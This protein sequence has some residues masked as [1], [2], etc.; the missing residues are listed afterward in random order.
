[1]NGSNLNNYQKGI[2]E[3]NQDLSNEYSVT[4]ENNDAVF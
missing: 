2:S 4:I 3:I 1:M